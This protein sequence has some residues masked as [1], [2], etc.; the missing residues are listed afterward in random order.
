MVEAS[1]RAVSSL[2]G[3]LNTN[4]IISNFTFV[5]QRQNFAGANI[6][7]IS[8]NNTAGTPGAATRFI[9]GIVV[10]STTCADAAN[11]NTS[12]APR[13]D[14]VL[15]DCPA[16]LNTATNTL[17]TGGT[18]NTQTSGS[19]LT[20]VLPGSIEAAR[21]ALNAATVDSFFTNTAYIGAFAPGS[22]T[23]STW[24]SG[25]TFRLFAA[26]TGCPVGTAESGQVAGQRRCIL[27]GQ[28]GSSAQ[29]TTNLRLE[30]GN[31]YQLA[32]RV[33]IGV[34]RGADGTA[35][36]AASLTIDA[37]VRIYGNSAG[38]MLV[39]NRGSQIFANGTTN[40]PVIFTS[41]NDL[42]DAQ[43][44][45]A[46]ASR[47][48]AGVIIA[49]RA[50]L[51]ACNTA[52]TAGTVTCQN[53][54]EGVTA[55]TGRDALFGGATATDN[56]GRLTNVQIRYP[57]AFLTSAA[58]G[59]DLNGLTLGGVGS[60]TVIDRVQ[61]HNSGDDGI[62]VFGGTVDMRRVIVTGALDDSLDFDEGWVGRVQFAL[63]LQNLT[64][65]GGP[66]RMVESSNRRVSALDSTIH[67]N[68]TIANFTFV[69]LPQN[70]SNANIQAISLN[71][72]AGTPGSSGRY[73]NGVVTGSTTCLSAATANTSPAPV[74]RS[75]LFSCPTAGDTAG[76]ALINTAGNN[77]VAN[78]TSTLTSR[79]V[80]GS[81]ETAA[82][83]VDLSTVDAWF[84]PGTFVGAVRPADTWWQTWS[85]GLETGSSC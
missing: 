81:G 80:N 1:N 55:A 38:D 37:G 70:F 31:V 66:D 15:F 62:E 52:T 3:T 13:F 30:A 65:T 33:D 63:V 82:T 24:A 27:S 12:P 76:L 56:S 54:V 21:P 57:G 74:F 58:A 59:D 36:T 35:G 61:V 11:A 72:S 50:P 32:G 44:T 25:W 69:G 83:A 6:Q 26:P 34:D 78:A 14:S 84:E 85:C 45:P 53:A 67:T 77:N 17:F 23:A 51:R 10:G 71:N 42:T 2:P 39:V 46:T 20:G 68:P 18:N 29:P 5:G 47:E 28:Y 22:T 16:A 9:N 64:I 40:A 60:G 7:G 79:F 41:L 48:W 8:L 49:G 4:P 19:S 73:I 43:P 75:V